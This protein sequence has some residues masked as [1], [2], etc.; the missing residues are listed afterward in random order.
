MKV[1][2]INN[3]HYRRGGADIVY[4]NTAQL[5]KEKGVE[6][7]FL[8]FNDERNIATGDR[9]Y[10]LEKGNKLNQIR[11]YFCNPSAA[12][13]IEKIIEIE[14]PDIAHA[15]LMWG[16]ITA[17]V[18]SVLHKHNI[19]IVHTVHDYRMVC[20]AYTFRNG[21]GMICE[22]CKNEQFF[23][24]IRNKCSKESLLLS[25]LMALEMYY[26]NKKWH[27]A[28]VLDGIIYVS[29]F[30][31][32]KHE[33]ID[34]RFAACQNMVLYNFSTVGEQ[35]EP[36]NKD[37][38]YY[39]YYGRL[40]GEK[41]VKTLIKTFSRFPGLRL[42]VVGTGPIEM[43]LKTTAGSNIDFLGYK[44]GSELYDLVRNSRFVCVPSEWYENNPMTIVESY[45]LGVPVIGANI[46]G[47]PEIVKVGVTGFL[48][49]SGNSESLEAAIQQSKAVSE[50]QYG[51][52]KQQAFSFAKENFNSK[53]Y[54]DRLLGFYN[55]IINK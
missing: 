50:Q 23:Q 40:S 8:S 10:F 7:V 33:E 17:S 37:G 42:K 53:P 54:I 16:G 24:C 55:D 28:T 46:G 43:E 19:P 47:I 34:P 20:P 29:K 41:G 22:Q 5:L 48:F 30:A 51:E 2:L 32:Q 1:L 31:K 14:Q 4:L 12:K 25:A 11:N 21:K 35:F 44:T 13:Q 27:P 18:V 3:C 45:S 49:E 38:D 26:R 36:A 52:M 15:H 39:L 6:V 9:E